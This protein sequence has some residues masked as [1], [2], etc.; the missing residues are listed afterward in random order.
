[1]DEDYLHKLSD[2][3]KDWLSRFNEEYIGANFD[4]EGPRIHP[5]KYKNKTVKATGRKRKVDIM[6]KDCGDRNNAR[7]RDSYSVTKSNDML[8][9]VVEVVSQFEAE[10]EITKNDV[11]DTLITILDYKNTED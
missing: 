10:R 3:E 11:E 7:N 8:K 2:K 9:E 6:K 5:K 4:H 1:M